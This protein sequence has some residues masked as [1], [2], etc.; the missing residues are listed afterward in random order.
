MAK[1][2]TRARKGAGIIFPTDNMIKRLIYISF[3]SKM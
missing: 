2:L 1:V 3:G